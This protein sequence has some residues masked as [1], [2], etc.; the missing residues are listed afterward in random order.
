MRSHEKASCVLSLFASRPMC[1]VK[2]LEIPHYGYRN[3]VPTTTPRSNLA[4]ELEKYSKTSFEYNSYDSHTYGKRAIAPKVQTRDISPKGYDGRRCT[5]LYMR[6]TLAVDN[7]VIVYIHFLQTDGAWGSLDGQQGKHAG[8]LGWFLQPQVW[9]SRPRGREGDALPPLSPEQSSRLLAGRRGRQ[10]WAR[11]LHA[12][13]ET[14][15]SPLLTSFT[16]CP[17]TD[18]T[19]RAGDSCPELLDFVRSSVFPPCSQAGMHVAF[20]WGD[21]LNSH[22]Q[23]CTPDQVNQTPWRYS[24][25]AAFLKSQPVILTC[26]QGYTTPAGPTSLL[27]AGSDP[28]VGPGEPPVLAL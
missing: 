20:I 17:G 15:S 24:L 11:L 19:G 6:V 28:G 8:S 18:R 7:V 5:L 25:C 2:Q 4:K 12:A 16:R 3:S 1:F 9:E 13:A 22:A 14:A 23:G 27:P 10:P 26:S 21:F